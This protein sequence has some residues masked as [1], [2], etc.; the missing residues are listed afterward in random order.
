MYTAGAG[1]LNMAIAAISVFPDAVGM[2]ATMF[3]PSNSP[4]ATARSCG[5]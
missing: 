4:A 2:A 1:A 5:G 3:A